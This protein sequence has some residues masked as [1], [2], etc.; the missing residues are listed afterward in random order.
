MSTTGVV[1]SEQAGIAQ[2]ELPNFTTTGV[3]ALPFE[4]WS[5]IFQV[6]KLELVDLVHLSMSCRALQ[7]IAHQIRPLYRAEQAEHARGARE[8]AVSS[9]LLDD[10]RYS[11]ARQQN[12]NARDRDERGWWHTF[13]N[14]LRRCRRIVNPPSAVLSQVLRSYPDLVWCPSAKNS[15]GVSAWTNLTFIRYI[16]LWQ[17][18]RI[19]V[20]PWMQK[21]NVR[22]VVHVRASLNYDAQVQTLQNAIRDGLRVACVVVQ[23]GH[24]LPDLVTVLQAAPTVVLSYCHV[25]DLDLAPLASVHTVALQH[26]AVTD[27]TALAPVTYLDISN[28]GIMNVAALGSVRTLILHATPVVDVSRLGGVHKLDLSHTKVADVSALG[29]V[30]TLTLR[31]CKGVVDVSALVD[32]HTL[33]L[34]STGVRD[35]S[36]LRAVHTLDLSETQVENV[37]PLES[38]TSLILRAAPVA[39]VSALASVHTLSLSWCRNVTDASALGNVHQLD[40]SF[41]AV[42]DV[43]MLGSVHNLNLQGTRVVDVSM[44]G[45]V[46][47]LNLNE[48]AVVDV[49]ALG[50]VC[51]LSLRRTRVVD[52]S[53][54]G[55]V[56]ALI[57]CETRVKD[58]SALGSVKILDVRDTRVVDFTAVASIPSLLR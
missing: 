7:H 13:W 55:Q 46:H 16:P 44:L 56:H 43:A 41:T 48:T 35:V 8:L 25:R 33:D 49:S 11:V 22:V 3:A 14:K 5:V 23:E 29:S 32:V 28:T 26:T 39:D 50:T 37:G 30:R 10:T 20:Q 42:T 12:P 2:Q 6:G 52:V 51:V 53:A 58:V 31:G 17:E 21:N 45:S 24:V 4:I 15:A 18:D 34:C 40:L 38:V 19:L 27:V 57:L 54:L 47:E 9:L 1:G 36:A